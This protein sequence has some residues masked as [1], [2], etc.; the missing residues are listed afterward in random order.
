ME[1][2]LSR[3]FLKVVE[4]A[5]IASARTMGFGER[6]VSDHAAVQAMRQVMDT[7]PMNGTIVIG[8]G[9]TRR[10]S[11]ALHWRNSWE[12]RSRPSSKS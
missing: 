2:D 11:H 4:E 5:A 3:E 8:E 9:R 6:K 12:E 1:Q 7:I 10:G